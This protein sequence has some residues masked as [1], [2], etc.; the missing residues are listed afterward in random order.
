MITIEIIEGFT[1]SSCV[2]TCT[3]ANALRKPGC[4]CLNE[5]IYYSTGTHVIFSEKSKT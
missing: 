2:H 3:L 5:L 1:I 4:F